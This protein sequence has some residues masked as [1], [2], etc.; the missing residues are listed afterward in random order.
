MS[1]WRSLVRT[2]RRP[3]PAAAGSATSR[4]TPTVPRR[5]APDYVGPVVTRYAPHHDGAPDPGEV[6]WTWVPFEEDPSRGKDR[7]VLLVGDD[8]PWLLG[9]MLTSKDHVDGQ[10]S[11]SGPGG[12]HWLDLGTGA[13]DSQRRPSEVRLDRVLRIDPTTVRREGAVLPRPVFDQVT[14]S[15]AA[16]RG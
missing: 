15:M 11:R 3:A 4:A 16:L 12:S 10:V 1:W 2:L 6:V 13:W 14:R 9:L 5:V 8:G 7:P